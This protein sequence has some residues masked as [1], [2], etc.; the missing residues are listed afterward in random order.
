MAHSSSILKNPTGNYASSGQNRFK[1]NMHSISSQ[2]IGSIYSGLPQIKTSVLDKS[3]ASP[4]SLGVNKSVVVLSD[5]M[6]KHQ[7]FKKYMDS[8]QVV[9]NPKKLRSS[10][11]AE[12]IL[13]SKNEALLK[14]N[15]NDHYK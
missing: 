2:H 6:T 1:R 12:E 11:P 13:K 5:P 8:N 10:L 4:T 15:S 14:V 3:G 9:A 7:Q